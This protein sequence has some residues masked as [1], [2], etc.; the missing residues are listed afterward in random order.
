MEFGFGV[1]ID[2]AASKKSGVI[3]TFQSDI[4]SFLHTKE[5]GAGIQH[6]NVGFI[7]IKTIPGFEAWYKARRQRFSK[8][9]SFKDPHGNKIS[10]T[11]IFTYDIKFDNELYDSFVNA[12]DE[13]SIK[14][15]AKKFLESLSYLDKL[16]KHVKDFKKQ[17]FVANI[18]EYLYSKYCL[19]KVAT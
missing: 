18:T 4:N 16:P 6:L 7:C 15:I 1:E 8:E 2:P 5:Y 12:T 9:Y 17:D 19:E 11:N 10:I 13:V 3:Q 14:I